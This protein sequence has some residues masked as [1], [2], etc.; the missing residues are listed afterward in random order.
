MEETKMEGQMPHMD[1]K[2][3]EE[4]KGMAILSYL[5]ILSLIPFFAKKDSPFV[6]FHAKQ[7]VTLFI[8]SVI[9]NVIWVI[10]I[11]GWFLG[12]I[13]GLVILVFVIMGIVNA[14]QGKTKELPVVGDL[15]KKL[16]K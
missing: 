7:G 5:Y 9:A 8:G 10:P 1:S 13:L 14:A 3:V 12:A 4:N 2:D 6:Q 11:L 15:A 16:F